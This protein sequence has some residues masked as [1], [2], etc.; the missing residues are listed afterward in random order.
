[1]LSTITNSYDLADRLTQAVD[2]G[3]GLPSSSGNARAFTYNG[4]DQVLTETD[5]PESATVTYTYDGEGRAKTLAVSGQP[6]V[7]YT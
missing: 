5:S 3:G 1:V 2:T 4:F 6:T 7:T